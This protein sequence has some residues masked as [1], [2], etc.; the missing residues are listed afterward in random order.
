MPHLFYL[1]LS[2]NLVNLVY[3]LNLIYSLN[4]INLANL[5][6]WL[7]VNLYLLD[8]ISQRLSRIPKF[9]F[10]IFVFKSID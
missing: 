7:F 6:I 10:H 8:F 9:T 1:V 5:F 3:S 4:M 2:L